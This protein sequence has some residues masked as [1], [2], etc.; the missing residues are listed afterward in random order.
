MEGRTIV[1]GL[2]L[3]TVGLAGCIGDDGDEDPEDVTAQGIDQDDVEV[4]EGAQLQEI[5]DGYRLLWQEPELPINTTL[6]LPEATVMV[7]TT[8][9]VDEDTRGF[10]NVSKA[11]TSRV[12]CLAPEAAS[13]QA[14]ALGEI[15][16]TGLTTLD[17]LPTEWRFE[18]GANATTADAVTVD[19][20]NLPLDGLLS[21]LDT[22]QLSQAVHELKE[23]ESFQVQAQ[24]GAQLHVE[25]TRPDVDGPVPTVLVSGLAGQA[26]DQAQLDQPLEIDSLTQ[27]LAQRGY[28]VAYA[29]VRGTGQSGGCLDM[30]GPKEQADQGRLVEWISEQDWAD[31]QLAT[32]GIGYSGT[33]AIEAAI[34]A[35]DQVDAVIAFGAVT[36]AY[37]D[38]HFGG[39]PN[40]EGLADPVTGQLLGGLGYAQAA[41]PASKLMSSSQDSCDAAQYSDALDPRAVYN[42]FYE[43]RNLTTQAE[44]ITAPMLYA[45]GLVDRATKPSMALGMVNQVQGPVLG[46]VGPWANQLPTRA[47]TQTLIVGFL[48][49]NLKR[50]DVGLATETTISVTQD[51]PVERVTEAWPP[52]TSRVTELYPGFDDG[53]LSQAPTNGSTTI[54]L[55]PVGASMTAGQGDNQTLV[56]LRGSV[57]TDLLV[58]GQPA[59]DLAASLQG[60]DNAFVAA[61]LY[62]LAPDGTRELVSFGMAN[63]AHHNGHDSY[64]PVT[65]GQ[66]VEMGAPMQPVETVIKAN[67]TLELEIRSTTSTDWTLVQPGKPGALTLEAGAQGT[68][69]LLPTLPT[70]QLQ[71]LPNTVQPP[72]VEDATT[73]QP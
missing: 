64:T 53:T 22:S 47:D 30:W 8:I 16:C 26:A 3:L 12:R 72:A 33:T 24:D 56:T 36:D 73:V 27:E 11:D 37:R 69:L 9:D 31:G 13:L 34:Q 20:L 21:D 59:L 29:H 2:L 68:A 15:S 10:L 62:D 4:P 39:V 57:D 67:H 71:E 43:A 49:Q 1:I 18:I 6:T 61:Y 41:E 45:Q 55:D 44:E 23:T 5:D 35:P 19:L 51:L 32:Y 52:S 38:W 48:D 66:L 42:A 40:G 7:N 17:D 58:A 50:Q 46:V 63:L 14:P 60:L 65:P 54:L 25:V 28:A 70:D